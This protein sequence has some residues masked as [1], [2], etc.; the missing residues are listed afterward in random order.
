MSQKK[1]GREE[2]TM[3]A[4]SQDRA[5]LALAGLT[6]RGF[7]YWDWRILEDVHELEIQ[8]AVANGLADEVKASFAALA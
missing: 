6:Y 5:H 3:A 8:R 7:Y 2:S 1:D 4:T